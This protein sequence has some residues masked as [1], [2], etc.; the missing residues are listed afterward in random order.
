VVRGPFSLWSVVPVVRGLC[1]LWSLWS[2]VPVHSLW[3][4]V[5]VACV[6]STYLCLYT[7][8]LLR[9]RRRRRSLQTSSR[10]RPRFTTI[11]TDSFD[12]LYAESTIRLRIFVAA[13]TL[14]EVFGDLSVF[15]LLKL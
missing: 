9:R 10:R 1:S 11:L 4:V 15:L 6:T 8:T 13:V 7:T 12:H 5:P 14:L 2:V 3:S